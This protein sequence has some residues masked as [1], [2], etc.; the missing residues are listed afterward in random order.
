MADLEPDDAVARPLKIPRCGDHP[1]GPESQADVVMFP[2]RCPAFVLE[3]L[4]DSARES[5]TANWKGLLHRRIALTDAYAGLG[6]GTVSKMWALEQMA[7]ECG[8]SSEALNIQVYMATDSAKE[9]RHALNALKNKHKPEHIAKDILACLYEKDRCKLLAIQKK[10]F[11]IYDIR[12]GIEA[13]LQGFRLKLGR[14]MVK[15]MRAVLR[16]C[17]FKDISDCDCGFDPCYW[18]PRR[19]LE[20]LCYWCESAGVTCVPWSSLS[21]ASHHSGWFHEATLVFL[22]Y[23]YSRRFYQPDR[24]F[25]ECVPQME[26]MM[27]LDIM[28]EDLGK[29]TSDALALINGGAAWYFERLENNPVE[30]GLPVRRERQWLSLVLSFS[31]QGEKLVCVD[32]QTAFSRKMVAD[33][34]VFLDVTD[35]GAQPVGEPDHRIDGHRLAAVAQGMCTPC[36]REWKADAVICQSQ[37]NAGYIGNPQDVILPTLTRASRFYD[38]VSDKPL[39][40]ASYYLAQGWMH[41]LASSLTTDIIERFP[42]NIE[43]LSTLSFAQQVK[44]LGN[45]FHVA[46]ST[47]HFIWASSMYRCLSNDILEARMRVHI[48]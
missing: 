41:P 22:V 6:T 21:Q 32:Y 38:L 11:R 24:I 27:I 29:Q 37:A 23:F 10:W 31:H 8:I 42:W 19:G 20:R 48:Q 13:D 44:L 3:S 35:D 7:Q 33:L 16:R 14:L 30:M 17:V 4:D 46:S 43:S 25:I 26:W 28:N 2:F 34:K 39:H 12:Y 15:E 9:S 18:S 40:I 45:G 36:L 5:V 1:V 47:S